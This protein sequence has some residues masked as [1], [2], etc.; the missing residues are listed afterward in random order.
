MSTINTEMN[1][2]NAICRLCYSTYGI[3]ALTSGDVCEDEIK[4]FYSSRFPMRDRPTEVECDRFYIHLFGYVN[5]MV[6]LGS[7]KRASRNRS[8]DENDQPLRNL[9]RFIGLTTGDDP[10]LTI[11]RYYSKLGI[12]IPDLKKHATAITESVN[13]SIV[14]GGLNLVDGDVAS[15]IEDVYHELN[16]NETKAIKLLSEAQVYGLPN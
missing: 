1:L 6:W 13:N 4:N 15:G 10:A 5:A 12:D 9:C 14:D 2:M 11:K 3:D 7:V 8:E 16:E